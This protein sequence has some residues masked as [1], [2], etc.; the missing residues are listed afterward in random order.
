MAAI[1]P[2]LPP[3]QRSEIF[4]SVSSLDFAQDPLEGVKVRRLDL[5]WSGAGE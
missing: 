2:D 5:D 4:G 3:P 1:V